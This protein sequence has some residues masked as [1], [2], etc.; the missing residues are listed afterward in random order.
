MP[1]SK[2]LPAPDRAV[3]E[4][5][6]AFRRVLREL[7]VMARKGELSSGLSPAQ[8]FVLTVV[9]DQPGASVNEIAEATLTDRSSAAAVVDRLVEGGF[10]VRTQSPDD[11]R[12]AAIT[13]TAAG[14]RAM[15]G[16]SPPPTVALL[17][18]IRALSA[19]DRRHLAAG[20]TALTREMGIA[21]QPAG[22]LFDDAPPRRRR[23]RDV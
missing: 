14:K 15:K 3:N 12:R 7:R 19:R 9:S 16:A 11:R 22:M 5:I 6:D 1:T 23:R 20:L 4:A 21:D 13:I 17:S 8:L 2:R 10:V 18:C